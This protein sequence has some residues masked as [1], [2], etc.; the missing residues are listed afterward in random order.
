MRRAASSAWASSTKKYQK[1]AVAQR[2]TATNAPICACHESLLSES[3][4]CVLPV[5][6]TSPRRGLTGAAGT[7]M[8]GST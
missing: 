1:P 5:P 8:S 6:L 4:M 2:Q 3:C 7:G